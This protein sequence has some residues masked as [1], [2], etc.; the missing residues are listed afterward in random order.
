MKKLLLGTSTLFV[1]AIAVGC[2]R[3]DSVEKTTAELF[4]KTCLDLGLNFFDNADVYG[5]G[6]CEKVFAKAIGMSSDLREKIYIQTKCGIVR[7]NDR[8]VRFDF[9]KDHILK[10]VDDSLRRLKTD[11]LDIL[12][13]HRP[14]ALAE[15][16]EI[17]EAFDV[18]I[19]KGKVRNFGVSNQDPYLIQLLQK[20]IKHPIIANQI[21]LSLTNAT[22][23]TQTMNMNMLNDFGIDRDNG[24]LNFCRLN[25]ITVQAW[26]PL[27][28]GA[29]SGTFMGNDN[30]PVLNAKLK[31]IGAKYGVSDTAIAIAWILRHPARIQVVTGTVNPERVKDCA[32]AMDVVLSREDWYDLYLAAGHQLP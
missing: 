13:L 18:L 14:D 24:I 22:L 30:Y 20:H 10:S 15:P 23:I 7:V 21:Q 2:M 25:N 4:V 17:A 28:F 26:S 1:P 5:L 8:N 3:I 9:S 6:E 27:Q 11:Y 12:L 29:S 31:E 32:K 16:E 19:S